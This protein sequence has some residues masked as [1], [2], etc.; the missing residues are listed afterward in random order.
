MNPCLSGLERF[1]RERGTNRSSCRIASIDFISGYVDAAL[2]C[3]YYNAH[4]IISA[5]SLDEPDLKGRILLIEDICPEM[6]DILGSSLNIDPLFFASHLH[7]PFRDAASQTPSL[8]TL[9]SRM[10]RQN[11]ISIH[12]HRVLESP[13]EVASKDRLIRFTNID[14]KVS[15]LPLTHDTCT[16]IVQHACSVMLVKQKAN[17]KD[18]LCRFRENSTCIF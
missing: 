5:I 2:R 17:R 13:K 7:A 6:I 14:R 16:S 12:Y 9:P 11:F 3:R 10:R 8:A 18:W 15:I 1:L 4:D